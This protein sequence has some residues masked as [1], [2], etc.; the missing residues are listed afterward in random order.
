MEK[1]LLTKR[2][3]DVIYEWCDNGA[4][5]MKDFNSAQELLEHTIERDEDGYKVVFKVFYETSVEE[6]IGL[7]QLVGNKF[8]CF[9]NAGSFK[10]NEGNCFF[11]DIEC[12]IYNNQNL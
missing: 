5:D 7:L 6:V 8:Q 9:W 4:F 12:F 11:T 1:E 3:S 10:E 2:I